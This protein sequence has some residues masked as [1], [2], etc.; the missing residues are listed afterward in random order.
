GG[1]RVFRGELEL[2]QP[3][4]V[5]RRV[6]L[7][8]ER[9]EGAE[10]V[11]PSPCRLVVEQ[12]TGR[13]GG[14]RLD[15]ARLRLGHGLGA[16]VLDADA[17]EGVPHRAGGGGRG[18]AAPAGRARDRARRAVQPGPRRDSDDANSVTRGAASA[19]ATRNWI[20]HPTS[21]A[22]AR[23]PP[24]RLAAFPTSAVA[25]RLISCRPGSTSLPSAPMI[26]PV[27]ASQRSEN[28]RPTTHPP[29]RRTR[30]ATSRMTTTA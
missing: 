30:V 29:S 8:L 24:K 6:A 14:D 5:D 16:H 13:D 20:N 15:D 22:L 23:M 21:K 18:H 10:A 7:L 25:S 9:H 3:P 28:A 19:T 17:G 2:R 11:R 4:S 1:E 12:R 27:S 26:R